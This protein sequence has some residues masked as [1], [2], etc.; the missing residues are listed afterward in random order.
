MYCLAN[1]RN[2]DC[3]DLICMRCNN[4]V[5][6]DSQ[7]KCNNTYSHDILQCNRCRQL[8]HIDGNC[9]KILCINTNNNN[10]NNNIHNNIHNN[11]NRT[12][13]AYDSNSEDSD[14]NI[15]EI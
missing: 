1:H 9:G 13:Y 11:N 14:F 2:V 10:N 6:I 15:N 8:G 7:C 4:R 12:D 5:N 3:I